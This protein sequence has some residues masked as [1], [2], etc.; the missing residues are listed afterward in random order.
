[1]VAGAGQSNVCDCGEQGT[2]IVVI[3]RTSYL[4]SRAGHAARDLFVPENGQSL[5]VR[6]DKISKGK[7]NDS[8]DI[9]EVC[10][11]NNRN[12]SALDV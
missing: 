6:P 9:G 3:A 7:K 5:H 11:I 8:N 4:G 12:W 10:M 1:V 2:E